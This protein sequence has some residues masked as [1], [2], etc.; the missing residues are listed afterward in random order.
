MKLPNRACVL[1]SRA[2]IG[3]YLVGDSAHF[4]KSSELWNTIVG[5][6]EERNQVSDELVLQCHNHPDRIAY[7]SCA[8]DFETKVPERNM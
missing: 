1:L 6:L 2:K 8:E 3:M 4:R 7:V 5:I